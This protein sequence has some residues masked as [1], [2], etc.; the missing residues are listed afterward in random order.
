MAFYRGE[1]GSGL[2]FFVLDKLTCT[3]GYFI[4]TTFENCSKK[5][6]FRQI[7]QVYEEYQRSDQGLFQSHFL[8]QI[9]QLIGTYFWQ[10]SLV[11]GSHDY[12]GS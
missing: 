4:R 10:I 1:L 5:T 2:L 12:P 9:L 7:Q 8:G 6:V 11:F 3:T